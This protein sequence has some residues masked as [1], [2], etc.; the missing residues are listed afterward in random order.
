MS[1][2]R[3][4][5]SDIRRELRRALLPGTAEGQLFEEVGLCQGSARPDLLVV[6]CSLHGFEIKSDRDTLRRL[7]RQA[8]VY[9][10]V[11][12]QVSL[13]TTKLHMARARDL[14]PKWWGLILAS[15]Q[16][17]RISLNSVR[18]PK[19]NPSQKA[20][21]VA[22]LLWR[23]EALDLLKKHALA[24][25]LR[26]KQRQIV[27]EKVCEAFELPELLEIVRN[28]LRARE[29]WECAVAEVR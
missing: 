4:S 29:D 23:E 25:G 10:D 1:T 9:C 27:W 16:D 22:Q 18:Q 17:D 2:N 11:L 26:T 15:R 28:T 8:A 19:N 5:D 6:N 3:I 7:N 13:V 21:A 12:D 20:Y 24:R 14:V